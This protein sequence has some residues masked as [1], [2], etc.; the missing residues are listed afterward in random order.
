M[1]FT[2]QER[3]IRAVLLQEDDGKEFSVVYVSQRLLDVETRYVFVKNFANLYTMLAS[4]LC[5]TSFLVLA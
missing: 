3:V 2:T 5:I 4:S 1:Y